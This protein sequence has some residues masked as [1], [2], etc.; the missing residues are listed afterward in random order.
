MEKSSPSL[1][2]TQIPSWL[3]YSQSHATTVSVSN[4]TSSAVSHFTCGS[5]YERNV[6]S[7]SDNCDH[8]C[9]RMCDIK[10]LELPFFNERRDRGRG[11]YASARSSALRC[12]TTQLTP[13]D[14]SCTR[15]LLK[16]VR[17][18]HADRKQVR[19]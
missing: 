1:V 5:F 8:G 6:H 13:S 17:I 16:C 10:L 15:R 12:N 9:R 7:S 14:R 19:L 2:S 18:Q 3:L 4:C 11:G